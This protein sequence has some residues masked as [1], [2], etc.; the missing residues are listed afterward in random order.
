MEVA[1][2][3]RGR[4]VTA[5]WR[6]HGGGVGLRRGDVLGYVLVAAL[7]C[8]PVENNF[9]IT[10]SRKVKNMIGVNLWKV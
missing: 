1:W 10:A 8:A 2:R 5:A 9:S 7:V 6:W 3:L 4:G